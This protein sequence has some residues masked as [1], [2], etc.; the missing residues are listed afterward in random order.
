MKIK[1]QL[2][3]ILP[4]DNDSYNIPE[5]AQGWLPHRPAISDQLSIVSF[6]WSWKEGFI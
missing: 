2:H 5:I 4:L 1:Y 6:N 3:N